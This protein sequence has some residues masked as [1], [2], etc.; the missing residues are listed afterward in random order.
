MKLIEFGNIDY[1]IIIPLIHPFLYQIRGLFHKEENKPIFMCFTNFCGYLLTGI[2][3]LII[4]CRMRRY[5]SDELEKIEKIN[6]MKNVYSGKSS[7]A[8]PVKKIVPY[9]L[10]E[11]QIKVQ[12]DKIQRKT[13]RNQYLFILLLVFIYLIPMLLDSY[14]SSNRKSYLGTS[15][16]FS[17]SFFIFFII[18]FSKIILGHKI[19]SHQIFSIIIIVISIIIIIIIFVINTDFSNYGFFNFAFVVILTGLYSLFNVLEKKYY[20]LYMDSPYHFMFMLGLFSSIMIL[21]YE[22]ITVIFSGIDTEFNGI[23]YKF[24]DNFG[25]NGFLYVLIFLGDILSAFIWLAGIQLTI[26]FFT[27]CH[28]IISESI[29]Q[30]ITTIIDGTI[31]DFDVAEKVIIYLFFTVILFAAFIYNEIFIINVCNLNKNTKK[32]ILIRQIKEKEEM[33]LREQTI[34]DASNK[35]EEDEFVAEDLISVN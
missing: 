24:K 10:G 27:P 2:I 17:V 8:E 21:L 33:L 6:E 12:T 4:K 34:E 35:A 7:S 28:F 29:S 19:Y 1:K 22:I 9:K 31:R 15:S 26:Y 25:E 3:Y 23:F 30:I 11:N 18:T 32:N 13:I 16:A 14:V 20:N 5:K